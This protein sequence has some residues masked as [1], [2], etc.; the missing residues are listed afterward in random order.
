MKA[1]SFF[2]GVAIVTGGVLVAGLV[3]ATMRKSV[4]VIGKAHS[5]FDS[6]L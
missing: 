3:M 1:A 4:S 2:S 5:G 6:I